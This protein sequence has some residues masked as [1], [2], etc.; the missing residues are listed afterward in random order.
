MVSAS[1][2]RIFPLPIHGPR[3][4]KSMARPCMPQEARCIA[5]KAWSSLELSK[6]CRMITSGALVAAA[7]R[8][9][10]ASTVRSEPRGISR[11]LRSMTAKGPRD[12]NCAASGLRE[13]RIRWSSTGVAALIEVSSGSGNRRAQPTHCATRAITRRTA[14]R[15]PDRPITVAGPATLFTK[16]IHARVMNL[17][18]HFALPYFAIPTGTGLQLATTYK[19]LS[20][21]T[22]SNGNVF[23]SECFIR[24][25]SNYRRCAEAV[26][27][28][29]QIHHLK[30]SGQKELFHSESRSST[31]RRACRIDLCAR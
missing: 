19:I 22:N 13:S 15:K 17:E 28:K 3:L 20:D 27:E 23:D 12:L 31:R 11:S 26:F 8:Y 29:R 4:G 24:H 2:A 7:H 9:K 16:T 25:R 30:E 1:S 18:S 21:R 6:P 14:M 5:W 10:S